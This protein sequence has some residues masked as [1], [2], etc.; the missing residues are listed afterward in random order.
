MQWFRFV[1]PSKHRIKSHQIEKILLLSII[2]SPS[3]KELKRLHFF[4]PFKDIPVKQG[5]HPANLSI[6]SHLTSSSH[7]N[8]PAR[9]AFPF[10][11]FPQP[12]RER[13]RERVCF[14]IVD[15]VHCRQQC[16]L[17]SSSFTTLHV[18]SAAS[19]SSSSS[20]SSS[21]YYYYS[22][23]AVHK[24][25]TFT[26]TTT[27]DQSMLKPSTTTTILF[28]SLS[29]PFFLLLTWHVPLRSFFY[30]CLAAF[31]ILLA[32]TKDPLNS[33]KLLYIPVLWISTFHPLPPLPLPL[34]L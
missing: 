4:L 3:S 19:S 27:T 25:T 34:H 24:H 29:F 18:F 7:Y 15:F 10:K 30:L 21:Y 1:Y 14:P 22:E 2:T 6:P 13:E 11:I 23:L 16:F 20:S 32:D 33:L 31:G 9:A 5:N 28:K 17:S 8:I 26:H 12:Q